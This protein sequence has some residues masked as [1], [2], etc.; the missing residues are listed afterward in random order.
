MMECGQLLSGALMTALNAQLSAGTAT[1]YS[2][3]RPANGVASTAVV[4]NVPFASPA[5]VVVDGVLQIAIANSAEVI[6]DAEPTWARLKNSNGDFLADCDCRLT[7]VDDVGQ[8]FVIDALELYTGASL[9]ITS[10]AFSA[11]A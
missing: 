10:G 4:A 8:E 1:F 11:L 3:A 6:S 7:S 9:K 2:G 5:G